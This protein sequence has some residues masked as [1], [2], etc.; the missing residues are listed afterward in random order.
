M[1][2]VLFAKLILLIKY[3]H[4]SRQFIE[5]VTLTVQLCMCSSAVGSTTDSVLKPFT[6]SCL[7]SVVIFIIT[8]DVV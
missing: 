7:G 1:H 5:C 3:S 4:Y 8:S 2:S 6:W